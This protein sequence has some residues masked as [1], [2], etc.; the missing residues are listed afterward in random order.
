VEEIGRER[1]ARFVEN[2]ICGEGNVN[3]WE[4]E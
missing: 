1:D 2:E 4:E 3:F